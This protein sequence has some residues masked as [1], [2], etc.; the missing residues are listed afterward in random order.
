MGLRTLVVLALAACLG[1]LVA[2]GLLRRAVPWLGIALVAVPLVALFWTERQWVRAEHE[3]SAIARSIAPGSAGVHC[4]RL[5]EAF[6]YAGGD[7]GR[8]SYAADGSADGPAMMT[9]ETCQS[10]T[11]YWRS[12]PSARDAPP[13]DQ[14]VA[15]HVLAHESRHLAGDRSESTTECRAMQIDARVARALGATPGQALALAARYATTVY[16]RMPAGYRTADC[17]PG[18]PLDQSPADGVWP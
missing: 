8:V 7:L 5:G 11:D 9:Y 14:V 4:Q 10:L 18:G 6:T 1:W 3:F 17:R 16:P 12:S 15:V 13:L 2:R